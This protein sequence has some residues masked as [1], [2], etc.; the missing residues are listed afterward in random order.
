M[1]DATTLSDILADAGIRLKRGDPGRTEHLICPRCN[2]GRTREKSL[3]VTVD[4]DAG[5]ITYVCHRGSC[6]W[7]GGTRT[8]AGRPM[9]SERPVQRPSHHTPEQQTQRPEWLYQAF[10]DRRIGAKTI[11][12]L[13]I[14]AVRRR[15][16]DLGTTDGIVFPYLWRG[17]VTNRKYRPHPAKNPMQQEADALHTLY[18][19]DSLGAEPAEVVWV[20]GEMDV[21]ALWECGIH[22]GV[23]LKDGAPAQ[24]TYREDDRRFLALRTHAD[25][26]TKAKRIILAGDADA[27]GMALRDELARRL[28]RH[29]CRTVDWPD[30]CKDAGDTL[31]EHGPDAVL[32]AIQEAQPYPI[33]GL[34]SAY[35][36]ALQ[37]LR[38]MPPP[39]VMTTGTGH[40]D[41][42][43]KLPADGRLI[44]VTGYPSS[45]K[46]AWARFVMMH[47]ARAANRRWCVFSPEMQ[48]WE[49]FIAACA[50]VVVGKTFWPVPG[51]ERMSAQEVA[52]AERWMT[53]RVVMMVCDA[54]DQSPTLDWWLDHARMAVLRDGITDAVIDPWNEVDHERGA[55]TETEYTGRALQRLKALASDMDAMFGLSPIRGSLC[56]QSQGRAMPHRGHM[57][58]RVQPIGTTKPTCASQC[59]VRRLGAHR[60][61]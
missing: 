37:R 45:G 39:A 41:A 56:Q 16:G 38:D 13:G 58:F 60:S 51:Q 11:H 32:T 21:A 9:T 17:E 48:P 4:D 25:V 31:R 10:A 33:E 36:G 27:P 61:F 7:R 6:G 54:E 53:D 3:A 46:T 18:N 8:G 35:G 44:V 5:G 42:M 22:H 50:E 40:T 30:G 1:A 2:G 57:T 12:S 23:T 14:Y 29:R 34:R 59:I 55:L 52:D 19:V 47:T 20:E 28:G 26:L 43:L 49:E 24:A 15:F